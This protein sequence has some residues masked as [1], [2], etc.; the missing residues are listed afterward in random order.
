M[1]IAEGQYGNPGYSWGL[2]KP[3]D[4][5]IQLQSD[6]ICSSAGCTQY[7]QPDGPKPHPMDYFVPNFGMDHDIVA[8][9]TDEKIAS[10]LVG[11]N[12]AFKTPESWEKYR[13]RA[14]DADYNFDPE[15][16]EDMR[17][18]ANS[19]KIAEAEHGNPKYAWALGADVPVAAESLIQTQD[20]PCYSSLGECLQTLPPKGT[21]FPMGYKV[22]NFGPDP[23]MVG[24]M[25][26]EKI[27]STMLNHAW[28]FNTKKS[29]EKWRNRAKDTAEH[30]NFDPELSHDVKITQNN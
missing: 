21:E 15:L 11:H 5:L 20:D 29:F 3:A 7:K 10:A 12:W 28:E 22:P 4:S 13:N 2:D 14:K 16:S 27:A 9:E 26:N 30:Y 8:S 1:K 6:P 17:T 23:D 25:E 18:N 19:M 24:T